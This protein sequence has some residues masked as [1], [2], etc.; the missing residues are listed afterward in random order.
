MELSLK[1]EWVTPLVIAIVGAI[2]TIVQARIQYSNTRGTV[3]NDFQAK[4]KDFQSQLPNRI[5]QKNISGE[6]NY[7][8]NKEDMPN[9]YRLLE[10]YW[11]LVFDEWIVCCKESKVCCKRL[12][13]RYYSK[14]VADALKRPDFKEALVR[15][16][17]SRNS[18]LGYD[19][20]FARELEKAYKKQGY[21]EINISVPRTK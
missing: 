13:N 15:L 20:E 2:W 14:G 1:M 17:S 5:N 10:S 12:W 19:D 11:W 4:F 3:F 16:I 8:P 9:Y 18:F 6:Y 7:K 21:G